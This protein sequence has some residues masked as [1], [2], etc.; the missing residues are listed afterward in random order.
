M[1]S[2]SSVMLWRIRM[3]KGR[4]KLEMFIGW[5][6]RLM[7][8]L[9]AQSS[10]MIGHPQ[11]ILNCQV[12]VQKL[13]FR[14]RKDFPKQCKGQ[15]Y[16]AVRDLPFII[17]IRKKKILWHGGDFPQTNGRWLKFLDLFW[18]LRGTCDFSSV[19]PSVRPSFFWFF[20]W[21]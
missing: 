8:H 13:I 2:I 6:K 15:V 14:T 3:N 21:S 7:L 10:T 17:V 11:L 1:S 20:A 9:T 16:S 12:T 5:I 19:H 4:L 18:A